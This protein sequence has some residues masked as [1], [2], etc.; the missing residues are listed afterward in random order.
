MKGNNLQHIW[1]FFLLVVFFGVQKGSAQ[2]TVLD[3]EFTY[4]EFLGV[5]K[6]YHPLVKQADLILTTSEAKLLKARG[7]F[8]PKLTADFNKKRYKDTEYYSLFNG[9]FKIPTW[10]GIELKAAFDSNQGDYINPENYVP[11]DGLASFGISVPV[12]QGLW[13]NKRMAEVKKGKLYQELGDYERTLAVVDALTEASAA[14][15]D[16]KQQYD[17]AKLYE[18]FYQNAKERQDW[19]VKSIVLGE[20]SPIDSVE[21]GINL[22]TRKL[23]WE[24]AN[25]KLT[26]SRLTLSNYLWTEDELPLELSE[27]MEP[28]ETLHDN[29]LSVLNINPVSEEIDF[30]NHPKLKALSTKIAMKDVDR[31]LMA[32]KLLP[33]LNV[34]YNYIA[35]PDYIDEY[36]WDDYKIGASLSFPILLRKERADVKIAK[37][38]LSNAEYG[39]K[40]QTQELQNKVKAKF[41]EL[42]SYQT[43]IG[44]NADLVNDYQ[45]MHD[46]EVRLFELGESS[47]FYINTR[48]NKLVKAKVSQIELEN[49]Y[50]LIAAELYRT[51]A[52]L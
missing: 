50:F 19:I 7:Y 40:F 11:E 45:Q 31:R 30:E 33:K 51:L 28:E 5:V 14:Y 1:L 4:E 26:K 17:K 25:L 29:I 18:Q 27:V 38:E 23:E 32:N 46:A 42:S 52:I 10:Y 20:L 2:E 22:K 9:S 48:E 16:W 37:A 49:E 6:K 21:S 13:I 12:G 36:N 39:L 35:T 44:M 24:Q 41:A 15:F 47:I 43:Q 34:N 3:S 8:D